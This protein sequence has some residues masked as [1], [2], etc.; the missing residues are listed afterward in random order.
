MNWLEQVKQVFDQVSEMPPIER[1]AFLD[2]ECASEPQ[3]RAEIEALLAAE[4][5]AGDFLATPLLSAATLK[6]QSNSQPGRVIG[7]Y[8]LLEEIVH[9][10]MATVYLAERVDGEYRQ[11][12]ALKLVWSSAHSEEIR[13]RFKQERQ[14]L[15]SLDHPNIARLLDGGAAEDGSP[16]LVME[17]IAGQSIT[18]YC[19]ERNLPI[20]ERLRLFQTVCAAVAYAHRNLIVHRDIKPGN[21]L[22]TETGTVKLLDFGIAKL[23]APGLAE[24]QTITGF[25][26]M[27]PEYASPEQLREETLTT[28]TDVYSLGVLLY[29]LLTGSHPH[30]LKERPTHDLIRIVCEAD[31]P[32]PS[33]RIKQLRGDL[34]NIVLQA[35]RKEPGQRYQTVEQFREDVERF[36]AGEPILARASTLHYRA[37]KYLR[38]NKTA[39]VGATIVLLLL[40]GMLANEMRRA[41]RAEAEAYERNRQIYAFDM[42][43]ALEAWQENDL[44]GMNATLEK[45]W[46]K[47]REEDWRGFEWRYLWRLAHQEERTI[48]TPEPLL[49]Y[50]GVVNDR[51]FL[52]RGE[53]EIRIYEINSGQLLSCWPTNNFKSVADIYENDQVWVVEN[54]HEINTYE[55]RTGRRV[56]SFRDE[57][58]PLYNVFK[59]ND[60]EFVTQDDEGLIKV[61]DLQTKKLLRSFS[62]PAGAQQLDN[63]I[64]SY[65]ML[66]NS[67]RVTVLEPQTGRQITSFLENSEIRVIGCTADRLFVELVGDLISLRDLHSGRLIARVGTGQG[68]PHT[69][70]HSD[71]E[72]ILVVGGQDGSI[73]LWELETGRELE[74]LPDRHED[75]VTSLELTRGKKWLVSS[76][77]DR[78]LKLWDLATGR[79]VITL[80]GHTSDIDLVRFFSDEQQFVSYG[81]K[82]GDVKIWDLAKV[83]QPTVLTGHEEDIYAVAVSPDNRHI[84]SVSKDHTAILWDLVTGEQQV[85]R[86]H[87]DEVFVVAFSPDGKLLATGGNEGI[88]IIWNVASGQ[89]ISRRFNNMPT[90]PR[91]GVKYTIRSLAFSP[92]GRTLLIG[93][94][95]GHVKLWDWA[96]D[97]QLREFKAHNLPNKPEPEVVSLRFSPDG[98]LLASASMEGTA[99]IWDFATGNLIATLTG[100]VGYVWAAVFSPDGKLLATCGHDQ[101][102]KL[103]DTATWREV[104][105]LIGHT[106]EV[107]SVAFTPDGSRLASASNDK[108]VKLWDVARRQEVLT[109]KDHTDQVWSVAFTPDGQ[110]MVTGSWDKTVRLY[111]AATDQDLLKHARK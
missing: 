6:L 74:T 41:R 64:S 83:S 38:R 69:M 70:T 60:Q 81:N 32:P 110:T 89:E 66:A 9:G 85:L 25:L 108:T 4:T 34:D 35:L 71:D 52:A 54:G 15:A 82:A 78:T 94:G 80:K 91:P 31:P 26:P 16:F 49:T 3:L 44:A 2:R 95:D 17:Y 67:R 65:L 68:V 50:C 48:E 76:S 42:D 62:S 59:L 86:G 75:W 43:R 107:F 27:T 22:V 10:G 100:H 111:R 21:I 73:K 104:A 88:V 103:W 106:N 102:I 57:G 79:Q 105:T 24:Q 14:I 92:D 53:K 51:Y 45:Y 19:Q 12:V 1:A 72:R 46:P 23:L 97:R 90:Q 18:C 28:A 93:S 37:G 29:E 77:N 11:Q 84:A 33:S 58:A 96:E 7:R 13:R 47:P 40:L 87:T 20:V 61:R 63:Y 98:K 99:K 56:N 36:L 39:V 30:D 8:R 109:L 55:L 101:T 5:E